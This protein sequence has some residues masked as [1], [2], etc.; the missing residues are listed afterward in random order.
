MNAQKV[1]KS[2]GKKQAKE[3]EIS[4]NKKDNPPESSATTT[5]TLG[6]QYDWYQEDNQI[7]TV[8]PFT[9]INQTTCRF[10]VV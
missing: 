3:S 4:T 9:I 1:T 6:E 8:T 5:E 7:E 10:K 2:K